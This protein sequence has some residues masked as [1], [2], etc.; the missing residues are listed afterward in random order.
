MKDEIIDVIDQDFPQPHLDPP[1][2][3]DLPAEKVTFDD[4]PF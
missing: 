2:D 4:P 3:Q 1:E